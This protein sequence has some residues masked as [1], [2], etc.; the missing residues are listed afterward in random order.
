MNFTAAYYFENQNTFRSQAAQGGAYANNNGGDVNWLS[1]VVDY[2]FNKHFDVYTGVS[3]VDFKGDW[4]T[5]NSV[6]NDVTVASGVR[7]KF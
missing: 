5:G 7:F 2:K 3:W 4:T 1:G 6:T